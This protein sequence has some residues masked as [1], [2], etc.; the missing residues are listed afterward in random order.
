M[1]TSTEAVAGITAEMAGGITTG[2]TITIVAIATGAN[3]GTTVETGIGGCATKPR[4]RVYIGRLCLAPLKGV[5]PSL[6]L[7]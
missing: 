3:I 7:D 2:I 4:Q 6:A 5:G 1:V